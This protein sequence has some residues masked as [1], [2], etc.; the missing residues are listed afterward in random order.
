MKILIDLT[1]T[2]ED[3]MPVFPGDMPTSLIQT[4]DLNIDGYN[5]HR[6]ETGMHAGTHIDGPMHLTNS[7]ASIGDLAPESFIG[8][9]CLLDVRNKPI[10]RMEPGYEES[11]KRDSIVLLYTGRDTLFGRAEYFHDYP[12]VDKD[13]CEFLIKK[14]IKM[15]GMDTP[16]PDKHPYPI[17]KSLLENNI[18]ILENLTHLESLLEYKNFEIIALPLKIKANGSPARVIARIQ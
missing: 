13:L 7:K 12:V 18:Y 9:G 10:I 2:I 16:S 14:G 5:D 8:P 3:N 17:H 11:I 1:L 6:L 15:L 4:H